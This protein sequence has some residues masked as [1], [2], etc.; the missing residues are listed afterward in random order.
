M[1]DRG[2]AYGPCHFQVAATQAQNPSAKTRYHLPFLVSPLAI[3]RR[4]ERVGEVLRAGRGRFQATCRRR[5]LI[6]L[7]SFDF[8]RQGLA[9][10]KLR[11]L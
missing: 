10:E 11:K 1:S 9:E 2:P 7:G 3:S 8:R 6:S 5:L 4:L